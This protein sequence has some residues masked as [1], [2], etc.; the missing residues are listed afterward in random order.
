MPFFC[1]GVLKD[2]QGNWHSGE[3]VVDFSKA[4]TKKYYLSF[5]KSKRI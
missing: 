2:A 1:G 3:K 5:L 4:A